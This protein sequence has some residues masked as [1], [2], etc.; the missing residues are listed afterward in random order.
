[1][2]LDLR[3]THEMF[4]LPY[5]VFRPHN[6]YGEHQ[7]LGDPYRNVLGIFM[8]QILANEPLT[9]FGD[10]QQTRAFSHI[11]DVAPV[12]ATSTECPQA[13][14]EVFNVGA[15]RPY[16]INL[17]ADVVCNAFGTNP[18]RRYLPA[19]TEVLNAYASHEKV[20]RVLATGPT[21]TL[22]DGVVRMARWATTVGVRSGKVFTDVEISDRLPPIWADMLQSPGRP[23]P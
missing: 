6:V 4:G 20:K 21:V 23:Q 10:G 18:G 7:N 17:L 12:I 15:D 1:V 22:E 19:R 9:I 3:A 2:E 5:I 8:K 11:D 13:Y 14:C 16:T